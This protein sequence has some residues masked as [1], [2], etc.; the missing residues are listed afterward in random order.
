MAD[1]ARELAA[2]DTNVSQFLDAW[3]IPRHPP[4]H[5]APPAWQPSPFADL[6]V[7]LS[8]DM[9]RISTR[10]GA[11]EELRTAALLPGYRTRRAA[12]LTLGIP[13]ASL[14]GRLKKLETAAGFEIFDHRKRP[15][16]AT[17]RGQAL[18]DE[19]KRLIA[20]LDKSC[21]SHQEG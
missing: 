16:A 21:E 5:S 12:A 10:V 3:G 1:I 15:V 8:P 9:E 4:G 6:G 19:A 11:L 13:R 20:L 14:N 17:N 2:P 18:L 7:P